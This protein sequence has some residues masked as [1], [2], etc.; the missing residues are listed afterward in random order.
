LNASEHPCSNL[1]RSLQPSKAAAG[2]RRL[3]GV[4]VAAASCSGSRE[5]EHVGS[6]AQRAASEL[7]R[8]GEC[9]GRGRRCGGTAGMVIVIRWFPF[10]QGSRSWFD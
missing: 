4:D 3:L 5:S 9:D 8:R 10:Q 7:G 1:T 6:G 2:R